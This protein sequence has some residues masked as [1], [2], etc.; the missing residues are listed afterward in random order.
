MD[1]GSDRA[2][3]RQVPS[4]KGEPEAKHRILQL[5]PFASLA[6]SSRDAFLELGRVEQ[7]GRRMRLAEQGEPAKHFVI[8]GSGR[9][10]VERLSGGRAFPLGHRGPGE[11]IGET[12]LTGATTAGETATVV[13]EAQALLMPLGGVRKLVA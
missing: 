5:S 1:L 10:R 4:A 2:K 13:D 11:T 12:A 7:L 8:L 9:V 3:T 6:A